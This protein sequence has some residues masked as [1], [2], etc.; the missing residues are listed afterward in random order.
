MTV[1]DTPLAPGSEY[2]YECRICALFEADPDFAR[3]FAEKTAGMSDYR[4][5]EAIKTALSVWGDE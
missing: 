5:K 2:E 3:A 1:I 4:L